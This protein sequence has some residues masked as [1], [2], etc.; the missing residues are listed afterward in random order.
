[1]LEGTHSFEETLDARRIS[2]NLQW[3]S[4]VLLAWHYYII[5]TEFWHASLFQLILLIFLPGRE[6]YS[7]NPTSK[8]SSN[9]KASRS[10]T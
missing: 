4:K 5:P 1:M 2:L 8:L 9:F 7:F 10:V 3:P 6:I